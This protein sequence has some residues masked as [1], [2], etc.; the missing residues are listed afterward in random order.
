MMRQQSCMS[1]IF[2]NTETGMNIYVT[3]RQWCMISDHAGPPAAILVAVFV[4]RKGA[5]TPSLLLHLQPA[6]S[7]P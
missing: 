4:Q 2:R 3:L 5:P 6:S 7:A 1:C